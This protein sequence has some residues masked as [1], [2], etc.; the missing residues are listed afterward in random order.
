MGSG[1]SNHCAHGG[2]VST[3]KVLDWRPFDYSTLETHE[4]NRKLLTETMR[5]I[6]LPQG[7]TQLSDSIVVAMPLPRWLRK[8]IA[9]FVMT[10]VYKYDRLLRNAAKLAGEA[11]ALQTNPK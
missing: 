1:A 5:L 11:A 6:P 2:K 9:Q 4:H 3:E 10:Q 8:P 7:G